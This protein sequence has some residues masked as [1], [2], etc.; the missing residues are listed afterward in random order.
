MTYWAETRHRSLIQDS[1]SM[2]WKFNVFEKFGFWRVEKSDRHKSSTRKG[3]DNF[4]LKIKNATRL[5]LES[6]EIKNAFV[7]IFYFDAF[8]ISKSSF[9][10]LEHYFEWYLAVKGCY[11]RLKLSISTFWTWSRL[12]NLD[13][14]SFQNFVDKCIFYSEK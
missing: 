8:F 7:R 2:M 6:T 11:E 13:F 5:M 10:N 3:I 12:K 1:T 14:N 4:F 9:L